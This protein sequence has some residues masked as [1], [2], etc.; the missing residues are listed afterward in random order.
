MNL[1]RILHEKKRFAELADEDIELFL[2]E[3]RFRVKSWFFCK[4][5]GRREPLSSQATCGSTFAG[6]RPRS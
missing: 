5:A 6:V 1:D 3:R 4:N 2:R